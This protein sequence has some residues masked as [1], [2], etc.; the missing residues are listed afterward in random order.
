MQ[1][2]LMCVCKPSAV[3]PGR[4]ESAAVQ[5]TVSPAFAREDCATQRAALRNSISSD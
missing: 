5:L 2:S 1:S 4:C 3:D